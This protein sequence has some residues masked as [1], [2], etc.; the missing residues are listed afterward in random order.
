M[1]F[2]NWNMY[3][4]PVDNRDLYSNL[5]H[6]SNCNRLFPDTVYMFHYIDWNLL[7]DESG[8]WDVLENVLSNGNRY[9]LFL[10]VYSLLKH[11]LGSKDFVLF[12]LG[13]LLDNDLWV[14]PVYV[15][16][17]DD[18]PH[19]VYGLRNINCLM[20]IEFLHNFNRLDDRVFPNERFVVDIFLYMNSC[21]SDDFGSVYNSGYFISY[22]LNLLLNNWNLVD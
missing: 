5:L 9:W 21:L 20:N 10:D 4:L 11:W 1:S 6:P 18:C 16:R 13:L 2:G 15:N 19:F 3:L 14:W 8:L 12:V 22:D 7:D 17:L